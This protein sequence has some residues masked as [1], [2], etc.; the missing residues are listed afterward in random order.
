MPVSKET[1][2]TS[3]ESGDHEG[4]IIGSLLLRRTCSFSPSASA[5]TSLNNDLLSIICSVTYNNLVDATPLIPVT[6]SYIPSLI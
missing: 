1:Y 4:E 2:A 6:S 3:F 5:T